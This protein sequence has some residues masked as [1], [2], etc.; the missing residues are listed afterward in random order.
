M[1][2][3][4]PIGRLT[5]EQRARVNSAQQTLNHARSA[6]LVAATPVD[7]V[8]MVEELRSALHNTLGVVREVTE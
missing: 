7:L 6:D 8:V 4:G 5:E 2:Q 3:P 1:N